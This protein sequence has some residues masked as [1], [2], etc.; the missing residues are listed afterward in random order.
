MEN[1]SNFEV[2]VGLLVVFAILIFAYIV[3]SIGD[4]YVFRPGYNIN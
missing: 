2:K 1:K 3:F 4:F